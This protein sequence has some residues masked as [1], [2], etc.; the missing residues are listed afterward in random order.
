MKLHGMLLLT[1]LCF[2]LPANRTT[3]YSD[4]DARS[5]ADISVKVKAAEQL[6]SI[7]QS[8]LGSAGEGDVSEQYF[9]AELYRTGTGVAQDYV[10]A[11]KWLYLSASA[12][13]EPIEKAAKLR[14]AVGR[15]MT[16]EQLAQARQQAME[17]Q[18]A[19]FPPVGDASSGCGTG[20]IG[21]PGPCM[22]GGD[23]KAP[24][25]LTQPLPFYTPAAFQA[26]IE[27]TVLLQCI[28]R[29]DGTAD[30]FRIFQGLGF[31]LDEAAIY[32]IAKR[33]HFQ[34]GTRRS[35]PVDVTANISVSFTLGQ[36]PPA[37]K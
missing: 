6:E 3:A 11:Y 8:A 37:N 29:K 31:G 12:Q 26:G 17:W 18:A 19:H 35:N 30:S 32:T 4:K 10:Q 5:P 28:V 9:V 1:A 15:Q 7:F 27:G 24:I 34:P 2:C 22:V 33:W 20:E 16:A 23:V 13:G 25:A 14:D 21:R 36:R